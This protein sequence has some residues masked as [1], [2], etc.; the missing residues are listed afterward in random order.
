[1]R[2][3]VTGINRETGKR[4]TKVIFADSREQA[5]DGALHAYDLIADDAVAVR[6]GAGMNL[7][8]SARPRTTSAEWADRAVRAGATAWV[9]SG[10][11]LALGAIALVV[12]ALVF[13]ASISGRKQD[14]P[15]VAAWFISSGGSLLLASF[16][17]AAVGSIAGL[18]GSRALDELAGEDGA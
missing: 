7:R 15:A 6:A 2:W 16:L 10:L 11:L 8:A 18:A 13:L 1:M 12:G 14:G 5:I 9:A 17:L 3:E 4:E